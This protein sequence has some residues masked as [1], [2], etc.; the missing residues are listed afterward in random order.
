MHG[1][2]T[3]M[4]GFSP[5]FLVSATK[6]TP[7]IHFGKFGMLAKSMIDLSVFHIAQWWGYIYVC[8]LPI[9]K[10]SHLKFEQL[11]GIGVRSIKQYGPKESQGRDSD[12]SERHSHAPITP[13]FPFGSSREI[14]EDFVKK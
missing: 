5:F 11:Q 6:H 1:P 12:G 14:D 8:S 9:W 2:Y 10:E 7:A 3:T 13:N 4:R